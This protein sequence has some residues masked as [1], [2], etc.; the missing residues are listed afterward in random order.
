MQFV[1][2]PVIVAPAEPVENKTEKKL[3]EVKAEKDTLAKHIKYCAYFFLVTGAIG[4]LQ[5]VHCYMSASKWAR[6]IV[7]NKQ[8]PWG[9]H[10]HQT[11]HEIPQTSDEPDYMS[12]DEFLLNDLLTNIGILSL[13]FYACVLG[14]GFMGKRIA[15]WQSRWCTGWIFR[16]VIA[17]FVVAFLVY[18]CSKK[19]GREF[20]EIF[21]NLASEETNKKMAEHCKGKLGVCPV[22]LVMFIMKSFHIYKVKC[23]MHALEK[24]HLLEEA[25]KEQDQKDKIIEAVHQ[26]HQ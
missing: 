4:F 25:K 11:A 22:M 12:R 24:I 7:D 1:T 26:M 13:I 21:K 17:A 18:L 16:K 3:A 20:L 10:K 8:L 23:F 2:Q 6:F 9:H 14:T 19:L 15:K 5:S